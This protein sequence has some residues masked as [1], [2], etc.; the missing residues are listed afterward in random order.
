M[1]VSVHCDQS[2]YD[3]YGMFTNKYT[4]TLFEKNPI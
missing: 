4:T 2:I 3:L 1:T